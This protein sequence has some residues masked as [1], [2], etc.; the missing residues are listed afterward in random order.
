MKK[1]FALLPVVFF[2]IIGGQAQ[3][4]V[5]QF[6]H[7]IQDYMDLRNMVDAGDGTVIAQCPTF[8]PYSWD[9]LGNV[10][11]KIS[12]EG[13]LVDSLFLPFDDVPLSCLF[14]PHP[15]EKDCFLYAHVEHNKTDSVT[16]LCMIT[17][18]KDLDTLN[19]MDVAIVDSLIYHVSALSDLF[20]DT[21]N[22]IIVSY[23]CRQKFYMLRVGI[24]GTV[25]E[26]R[27]VVFS[28]PTLM[29]YKHTGVF[30]ISPLLYYYMGFELSGSPAG[31]IQ[32]IVIDTSFQVVD[33]HK[34]TQYQG[35][36][37]EGGMQEHITPLR[38]GEYLLSSRFDKMVYGVAVTKFSP[39]HEEIA[40]KR[41][42]EGTVNPGVIST[43]A[44]DDGTIYFSYMTDTG[45]ANHLALACLDSDLNV[46]W[47]RYFLDSEIF[48][49]G[50]NMSIS[51]D[52]EVAVGS[53]AYQ[54][55]HGKIS[56]VFLKDDSWGINETDA[57][58]RPYIFYPNPVQDRLSFCYSPDVKPQRVALY[59][60]QGRELRVWGNG[61]EDID[62]SGLSAGV[63][64][65]R[66][67]LEGGKSYSDPIVKE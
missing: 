18:G 37:Y 4:I 60:L 6:F 27:E 36:F 67:T 14:V 16:C 8:D 1:F 43:I 66:V 33:G 11:Y 2:S 19:R 7:T 45:G 5:S 55:F 24:D 39:E 30:S 17:M 23:W 35:A 59:D 46:Q 62:M 50:T 22:D 3:T 15:V 54:S 29:P 10:F 20:L 38:N 9:D 51:Q 58:M 12:H 48:F 64:T 32:S 34:Y 44:M 61:F 63:Y 42:Y 13:E 28:A 31:Y 53:Y 65:L 25:Q 49:W 56:V 26:P 21:N 47:K 52:G 40:V 57:V 41:F